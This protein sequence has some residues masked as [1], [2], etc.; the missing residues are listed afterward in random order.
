[1]NILITGS[2]GFI[3]SNFLKGLRKYGTTAT[4]YEYNRQT[5]FEYM[6]QFCS[7]SDLIFHFAGASRPANELEYLN[8]NV[9]LTDNIVKFLRKSGNHCPII[10]FSSIHVVENPDTEYS[11][12]KLAA[13]NI[14]LKYAEDCK[15]G[16]SIYRLPNVFGCGSRPN[17]T[18]VVA[19]FCHNI[20]NNLPI[21]INNVNTKLK[22]L[23][24][25]DL[26]KDLISEIDDME[27]EGLVYK[28]VGPIYDKRLI[29]IASLIADFANSEIK[30]RQLA[31]WL[32]DSFT[33]KLYQ[34]YISF[35]TNA[36]PI[37]L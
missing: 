37:I 29:E 4:L 23:Y 24:I 18:S 33:A 25:N 15:A 6:E 20:A 26:V 11:K 19:T 32:Q 27:Q 1:M 28:E 14:L 21:T 10:Y 35:L 34:T 7:H 22:L 36:V 12:T 31:N 8:S 5:P 9:T 30:D 17:Y 3:G 16:V 13:E 2:R